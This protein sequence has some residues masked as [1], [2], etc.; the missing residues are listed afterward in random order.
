MVDFL[1]R[2]LGEWQ[3]YREKVRQRR[4]QG[5]LGADERFLDGDWDIGAYSDADLKAVKLSSPL[6]SGGKDLEMATTFSYRARSKD[7]SK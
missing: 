2:L 3:Q 6:L 4:G 1:E 5:K 7:S